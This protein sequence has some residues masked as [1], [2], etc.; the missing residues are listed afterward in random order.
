MLLQALAEKARLAR[1]EVKA[2]QNLILQSELKARRRV[3]RRLGYVDSDG[4]VTVKGRAAA[5]IQSADELVLTELIFNGVF[6]VIADADC[7]LH[8]AQ[9]SL[10]VSVC[11]ACAPSMAHQL[12]LPELVSSGVFKVRADADC[13]VHPADCTARAQSASAL[14]L[15]TPL[16]VILLLCPVLMSWC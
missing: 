6:K 2:A 7:A 11:S 8:E 4:V 5:E 3:L 1:K 14:T 15:K 13:A 10:S 12:I 16:K 9:S